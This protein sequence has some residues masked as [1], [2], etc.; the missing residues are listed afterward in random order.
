MF[1]MSDLLMLGLLV[2][3]VAVTAWFIHVCEKLEVMQ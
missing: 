1:G 3:I 2:L